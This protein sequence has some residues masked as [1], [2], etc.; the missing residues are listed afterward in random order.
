MKYLVALV[1]ICS[2]QVANAKDVVFNTR[3]VC[4]IEGPVTGASMRKA[5]FCLV[6]KV[7]QRRGRD[8]PIYLYLHSPGGSI[9]QGLR[10]IEFA[11]TIK[12]LH[13]VTSYAASMGAA[14]VQHLPGKRY[15]TENGI[16]MFHRAYGRFEGQFEDGELERRIKF[17]KKIVRKQEQTQ[18][19]RIG[20]TLKDYKKRVKDE[21]W[22]YGN[23][24]V[25]KNV[26]D[27][28]VSAKCTPKLAKQKKTVKMRSLFGTIEKTVSGCPLLN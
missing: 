21:W 24:S 12:N 5:K 20:I 3:N 28:V 18:A 14:I 17:W 4:S 25:T 19:D 15:V 8:Y 26:A 22:L 27:A 6:D 23:E 7:S 11:K 9:Y 16:F 1:F 2:L 10:F 13:T